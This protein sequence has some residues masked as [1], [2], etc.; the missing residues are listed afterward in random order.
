MQKPIVAKFDTMKVLG[1]TCQRLSSPSM[2]LLTATIIIAACTTP[3]VKANA[4]QFSQRTIAGKLWADPDFSTLY[5]ALEISGLAEFFDCQEYCHHYTIFCPKDEAFDDFPHLH[6]FEATNADDDYYLYKEH[7]KQLVQYHVIPGRM[8]ED[9]FVESGPYE[10][11][12]GQIIM[13]TVTPPD[14]FEDSETVVTFNSDYGTVL[15]GNNKW[16]RNGLMQGVTKVLLPLF[17]EETVLNVVARVAHEFW[18][19][20]V[21]TGVD[22][23]L[24]QNVFPVTIL[25]PSDLAFEDTAMSK[26]MLHNDME[27]LTKLV[28]YH[29]ISHQVLLGHDL[30]EN[31]D[32]EYVT[33]LGASLIFDD[34]VDLTMSNILGSNGIVHVIDRILEPP[35]DLWSLVADMSELD[36]FREA[37]ITAGL[38]ASLQEAGPMTLFAPSNDAMGSFRARKGNRSDRRDL[39][40]HIVQGQHRRED[41]SDRLFR[42]KSRDDVLVDVKFDGD[43]YLNGDVK[44]SSFNQEASNGILHIIS[45]RLQRPTN[46]IATATSRGLSSFVNAV[47]LTGLTEAF[48][49]EGPY[50]I[51][52]WTNKAWGRMEAQ[53]A[54][55]LLNNP[56]RLRE[57]VLY[58]IVPKYL[59]F[60]DLRAGGNYTTLR[61]QDLTVKFTYLNDGPAFHVQINDAYV[62][63][64]DIQ[65]SNGCFHRISEVLGVP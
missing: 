63:G 8:Y 14:E 58:H 38:N 61:Q 11:M 36:S 42:T 57:I 33:L 22:Q 48:E 27:T 51:F 39:L 60:D 45:E 31:E 6:W 54:D 19:A 34:N 65:A 52:A 41:L 44:V 28:K 18:D 56:A 1:P 53:V 3:V 32:E 9:D 13:T 49:E 15:L 59:L 5:R 24:L 40:Y 23:V 50:T 21:L 62:T 43:V 64:F 29:I 30:E 17:A 16:A 10:T 37:M 20:L 47:S 4:L 2:I 26:A 12:Q 55:D 25:A 35:P 7:L 46:L